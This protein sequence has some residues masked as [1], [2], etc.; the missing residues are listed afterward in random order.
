LI[1]WLAF[2]I[3]A[4]L[5]QLHSEIEWTGLSAAGVN[6]SF[7]PVPMARWLLLYCTE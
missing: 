2:T 4:M 3:T 5:A 6:H 7:C 1:P